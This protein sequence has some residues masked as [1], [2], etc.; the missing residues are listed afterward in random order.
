MIITILYTSKFRYFDR[1]IG[2]TNGQ[3]K[4]SLGLVCYINQNAC[5]SHLFQLKRKLK[6]LEMYIFN[7]KYLFEIISTYIAGMAKF[8]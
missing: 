8:I 2:R 5:C 1:R 7:F 3:M 4:F 6:S